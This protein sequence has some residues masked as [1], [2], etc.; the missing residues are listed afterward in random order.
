MII[1]HL[2]GIL[3][4]KLVGDGARVDEVHVALA[5]NPELIQAVRSNH[6]STYP[7]GP[8]NVYRFEDIQQIER[9][10]CRP[11]YL[12][13]DGTNDESLWTTWF[14]N[15]DE[16][17]RH[18][19]VPLKM[20]NRLIW[21]TSRD[22]MGWSHESSYWY[23]YT[24]AALET[25]GGPIVDPNVTQAL[26]KCPFMMRPSYCID[27]AFSEDVITRCIQ[28]KSAP[29]LGVSVRRKMEFW[30][31][32]RL[33]NLPRPQTVISKYESLIPYEWVPSYEMHR[34]QRILA[35]DPFLCIMEIFLLR[36][37]WANDY[38][39]IQREQAVQ[40]EY[41][42]LM[43][44]PPSMNQRKAKKKAR[45]LRRRQEKLMNAI[46]NQSALQIELLDPERPPRRQ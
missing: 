13:P 10:P 15:P 38:F 26:A 29:E 7:N 21:P 2:E 34:T 36:M 4:I 14:N 16:D 5:R 41:D 24:S 8:L 23:P 18:E 37:A 45:R 12:R 28:T 40:D 11:L 9:I 19:Y 35:G 1:V 3:E 6:R 42:A 27:P 31:R 43:M 46:N 25:T 20:G 33:H 32:E 44:A 30:A 17:H 39:R 22:K